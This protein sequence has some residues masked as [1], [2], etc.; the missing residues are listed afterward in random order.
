MQR[1]NFQS[2]H[3]RTGEHSR[4]LEDT[5]VS[6]RS[7]IGGVE[8]R[9]ALVVIFESGESKPKAFTLVKTALDCQVWEPSNEMVKTPSTR[10]ISAI[11]PREPA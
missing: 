6:L 3:S 5:S 10:A 8:V 11:K 9:T 1:S 4:K 2:I 7:G